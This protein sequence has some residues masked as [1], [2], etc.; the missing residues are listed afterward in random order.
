L[1]GS[2]ILDESDIVPRTNV[3][4]FGSKVTTYSYLTSVV[5]T[6]SSHS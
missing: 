1:E 6:A 2:S 4:K 5:D 3:K